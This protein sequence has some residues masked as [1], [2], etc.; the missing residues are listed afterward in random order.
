M[1]VNLLSVFPVRLLIRCIE[2]FD[3]HA[4]H[5]LELGLFRTDLILIHISYSSL[6]I[7]CFIVTQIIWKISVLKS[8]ADLGISRNP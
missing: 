6:D 1:V 7:F 4:E 5:R 3:G 2:F 8:D